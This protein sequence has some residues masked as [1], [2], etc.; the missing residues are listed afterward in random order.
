MKLHDAAAVAM[1]CYVA[2]YSYIN[3]MQDIAVLDFNGDWAVPDWAKLE[4]AIKLFQPDSCVLETLLEKHLGGQSFNTVPSARC[5]VAAG[6][7]YTEA[8]KLIS[9]D[10]VFR[11]C[12]AA[13]TS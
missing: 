1:V 5:P 8:Q 4:A 3:P 13:T 11:A 10:P 7:N 6:F 12:A 2:I 9:N